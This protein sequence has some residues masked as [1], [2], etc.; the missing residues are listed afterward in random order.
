MVDDDEVAASNRRGLKLV[1]RAVSLVFVALCIAFVVHLL[2]KDWPSTSSALRHAQLWWL[3]PAALCAV[4]GMFL[5][6]SRWGAAIMAVGGGPAGHHRLISA[7]FVGEA[8]KYI[9]GA[10]WAMLGRG[11]LARREGYERAVAYSS[12]ALSVIGCYLAAAFTAL[13]L[14]VA[15][16]I[17]GS[18]STPWWPVAVV[19][20]VG[21]TVIHPAVSRRILALVS[22]A[23]GRALKVE[24]PSWGTC[25]RL[26]ATYIPVWILIAA[27]TTLVSKTLV[28]DPPLARVAL[29]AVVSWIVGFITPSPGGIGVREAVFVATAGL[30]SGPAAA[31]AI[32]AR[33]LFVLVDGSGAGVGWLV[34]R[35]TEP[36]SVL[37]TTGREAI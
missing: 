19:A 22:R 23:F 15:A 9:P 2:V 18:S 31:V 21:I 27:A 7:F 26:T 36:S 25:L 37:V 11:E 1:F 30:A 5:L 12:V 32:L 14:A 13:V 33:V 10:V 17:G 35:I 28:P 6:A 4:L 20:A 3:L 29:A 8:G 24:I 34:L 16:L